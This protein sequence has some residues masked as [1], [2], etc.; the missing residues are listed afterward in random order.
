MY[1]STSIHRYLCHL[2]AALE[3]AI[4]SAGHASSDFFDNNTFES[5]F[6]LSLPYKSNISGDIQTPSSYKDNDKTL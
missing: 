6:F 5:S 3:A 1:K 4:F 2:H